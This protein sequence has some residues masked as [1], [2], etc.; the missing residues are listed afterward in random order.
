MRPAA[1][2][3]AFRPCRKNQRPFSTHHS[4]STN[5]SALVIFTGY[6]LRP[7]MFGSLSV[8]AK[9]HPRFS[10]SMPLQSCQ[11]YSL[12]AA[13]SLRYQYHGSKY[14]SVW[15]PG[16]SACLVFGSINY[17]SDQIRGGFWD[18]LGRTSRTHRHVAGANIGA[19]S[20]GSQQTKPYIG[21]D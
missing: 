6:S 5:N 17:K 12:S 1:A 20:S 15:A 11:N 21:E 10:P 7:A 19:S 2:I 9:K 4:V 16:P 18:S 14:L 3:A 8:T 13:C